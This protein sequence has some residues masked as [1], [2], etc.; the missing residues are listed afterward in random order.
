M[1]EA[2]FLC[3]VV[4]PLCPRRSS[5]VA[6]TAAGTDTVKRTND[7]GTGGGGLNG[8]VFPFEFLRKSAEGVD[9]SL[10]WS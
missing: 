3:S 1:L 10:L 8:S 6:F 7:R 2:R 5:R 9:A 4:S